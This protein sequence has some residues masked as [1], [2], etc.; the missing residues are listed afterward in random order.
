MRGLIRGAGALVL[1]LA[2]GGTLR[3]QPFK[4]GGRR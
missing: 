2:G 3:F 4:E 1:T